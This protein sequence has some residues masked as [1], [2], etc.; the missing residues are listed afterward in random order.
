MAGQRLHDVVRCRHPCP[1]P[2]LLRAALHAARVEAVLDALVFGSLGVVIGLGLSV[3]LAGFSELALGL[4]KLGLD[5]G[6]VTAA[7]FFADRVESHLHLSC[8]LAH[9][10]VAHDSRCY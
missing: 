5:A 1:L 6:V 9:L 7:A 2:I 3:G 10:V 8:R 4:I